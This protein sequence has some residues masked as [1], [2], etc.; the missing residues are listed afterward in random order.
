MSKSKSF[1]LGLVG[2]KIGMTQVFLEDGSCV[3]VTAIDVS[4]HCVL[5]VREENSCYQLRLG[6]G[7]TSG[8]RLSKPESGYFQKMGNGAF[9]TLRE[10]RFDSENYVALTK[11]QDSLVGSPIKPSLLFSTNS[12]VDA[13]A[14]SIGKGFAGVVKR[15]HARGQP[16]TRGT[17]E[18]RRHVGSIGCRKFPG[19][20]FK[21]KI[22]PGR[23]GGHRTTIQNLKVVEVDDV[24]GVVLLRGAVPGAIGSLVE[25][26]SAVKSKKE[27]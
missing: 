18:N 16:A 12:L 17:H 2:S 22:M 20:V 11:K 6:I 24:N 4:D 10:V 27:N 7:K 23:L 15:F 14:I 13:S 26:R 5:E 21:N 25:I 8:N 3:P 19:R 9:K 1:P